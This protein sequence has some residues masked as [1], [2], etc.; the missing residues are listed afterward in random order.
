MNCC[1]RS[2]MAR[3]ERIQ[4][5]PRFNSAHLA[6]AD[7]IRTPAQSRLQKIVKRDARLELIRLAFDREQVRLLNPK[8][9]RI[10]NH[11]DAFIFWNRLR[12]NIQK[13]G[14]SGARSATD[15]QRLA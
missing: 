3:I 9:G 15:E 7:S 12:K 6:Q 1:Q 13:G 10:L 4:Q 11:N 8:L 14:L 2:R 5:R